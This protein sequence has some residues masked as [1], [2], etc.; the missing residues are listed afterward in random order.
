MADANDE[1][2]Y[3]DDVSLENDDQESEEINEHEQLMQSPRFNKS[4]VEKLTNPFFLKFSGK[5]NN[6]L[7]QNNM[8]KNEKE[9]YF[10]DLQKNKKLL[11][12]FSP[13]GKSLNLIIFIN[14]STCYLLNSKNS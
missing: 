11:P 14:N 3:D 10:F 7:Y 9:K 6:F 2:G 13:K 1:N 4:F 5:S 12:Y 8:D